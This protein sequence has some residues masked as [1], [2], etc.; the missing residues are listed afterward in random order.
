MSRAGRQFYRRG[1]LWTIVD[2][3]RLHL[4][5]TA[6]SLTVARQDSNCW[7]PHECS[8]GVEE[9][10]EGPSD[11]HVWLTAAGGGGDGT[12]RCIVVSRIA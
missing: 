12:G 9:H 3:A 4:P 2:S 1:L 11:A 8:V 7:S 6:E 5:R 10:W